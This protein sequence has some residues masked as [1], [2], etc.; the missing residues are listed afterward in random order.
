MKEI[1]QANEKQ[2]K[3]GVAIPV[4]DKIDFKLKLVTKD[5]EGLYIIKGLIYQGNLTIV[6]KYAP[7]IKIF[8]YI[9]ETPTDLKGEIDNTIVEGELGTPSSAMDRSSGQS[10]NKKML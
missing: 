7:N 6:N 8:S 9:E 5:K 1:F 4:S 2:K 10:I 3:V